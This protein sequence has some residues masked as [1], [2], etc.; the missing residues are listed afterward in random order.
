VALVREQPLRQAETEIIRSLTLIQD[1]LN[2]VA[3]GFQ[4]RDQEMIERVQTPRCLLD[5]VRQ[6]G[7]TQ[8]AFSQADNRLDFLFES[9]RGFVNV[10]D[11]PLRKCR[12]N[13]ERD[14][15]FCWM[16]RAEMLV[17]RLKVTIQKEAEYTAS[18]PQTLIGWSAWRAL[19]AASGPFTV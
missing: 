14:T 8:F 15:R 17:I 5:F 10:V 12:P 9:R 2:V 1:H 19:A 3:L 6:P 18:V 4:A 7:Q 16:R 11:V 13:T